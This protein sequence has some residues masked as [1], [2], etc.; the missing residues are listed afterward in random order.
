MKKSAMKIASVLFPAAAVSAFHEKT[1]QRKGHK[2][3]KKT[4]ANS[5]FISHI[6]F[7]E[8]R[9]SRHFTLI[10]L[11]VVIAIIAILAGLLL[12]ALNKA[13]MTARDISCNSNLKQ[14][15]LPYIMYTGDNNGCIMPTRTGPYSGSSW[16]GVLAES[17][18]K[19]PSGQ[20]QIGVYAANNGKKFKL[21]ECPNETTPIG[22]KENSH[23]MFGH[24]AVNPLFVG[25]PDD[26]KYGTTRRESE[27]KQAS[28]VALLFDNS[29]KQKCYQYSLN[30]L[31]GDKAALR[32]G[33]NTATF[34]SAD[35][36]YYAYGPK[37]NMSFYDGHSESLSRQ[38]FYRPAP[39]TWGRA[40]LTLGYQNSY[41]Y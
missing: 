13:R 22:K 34:E 27:V 12:P 23:F 6:S 16:P 39:G 28:K 7:L 31:T 36:K 20:G 24:F 35:F 11:L 18:Y 40:I 15:T 25:I 38:Y 14:L 4:A 10:E 1:Y 3:K 19:I 5:C 37:I 9:I 17:L 26:T 8:G 32:H 41:A 33:R 2:M 29:E 21:F 30:D